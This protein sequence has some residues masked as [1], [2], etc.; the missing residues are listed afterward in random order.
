MS[1]HKLNKNQLLT[2]HQSNNQT[3]VENY[4]IIPNPTTLIGFYIRLVCG[5]GQ[6]Q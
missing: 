4:K 2:N 5:L 6:S 1:T 3:K